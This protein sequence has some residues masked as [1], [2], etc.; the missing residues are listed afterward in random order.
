[1][2]RSIPVALLVGMW[3]TVGPPSARADDLGDARRA[4]SVGELRTAQ[5][6]LRNAV[7]SDPRNPAAHFLLGKVT[8]ELGDPVAAEREAIAARDR[9]FDPRQ[10]LTLLGQAL[11][12][13]GKYDRILQ[14]LTP[15]EKD[16][17]SD[18]AI[19]VT[20]G[21]AQF[22]LN[23]P[24]A[25][26]ASFARAVQL[27]PGAVEPLLA[28]ARLAMARS[29]FDIAQQK[30]DQ[31]TS[32]QPGSA[33]ALYL[34]AQLLRIRGDVDGAIAELDRLLKQQPAMMQARLSRAAFQLGKGRGDLAK[35][36]LDAVLKAM[37]GSVQGIYLRAVYDAQKQDYTGADH[38]LQRILPYMP[39]LPRAFYLQAVVKEQ[40]GQLEQAQDAIQKYLSTAPNELSGYKV[41]ARIRFAQHRPDQVVGTLGKVADNANA[42]AEIY[43]LL[44][45]A[46]AVTNQ[47]EAALTAFQ[48]GQAIAPADVGLQTRLAAVRMNL[49]QIDEAMT[50]LEQSLVRT[51][52]TPAI[53]EALFFAALATGDSDKVADALQKIKAAQGDTA[54]TRNLL[55]LSQLAQVDLPAARAT[56]S[57]LADENPDFTPARTN[58]ARVMLMM[59]EPGAAET[60]LSGVL[61]KSPASEPALAMLVKLLAREGREVAA[62]RLLEAAHSADPADLRAIATLGDLYIRSGQ[63]RRALDLVDQQ[64]GTLAAASELLTIRALAQLSL[65]QK[66][67]ASETYASILKDNPSAL[68]ARRQ[69]VALLVEQQDFQAARDIVRAGI[70]INPRNYQLYQDLTLIDVK[71]SGLDT[72]IGT[73]ARLAAQSRDFTAL[74][75]LKG[76]AYIAAD[77]PDRAIAAFREALATT[78]DSVLVARLTTTYLRTGRPGD[79]M[80]VL[81][82][83]LADH[84][85]DLSA[86]A[87]LSQIEITQNRLDDA[88]DLL[89]GILVQTPHDPVALN[90]LAWIYQQKNDP[91][92]TV[93][94]RRA[95]VLSPGPQTADTL[96]WILTA[97]GNAETGV[98]LL[99]QAEGE[100]V[101]DPRVRYHYAV[102][103][104]DLGQKAEAIRLLT[105]VVA[106]KGEFAEKADAQKL[107]TELG[108]PS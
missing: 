39:R 95:F 74:Q 52:E 72:A 90:N 56:F 62:E 87:Q 73:A 10:S 67:D 37:P 30:I 78:Q 82:A 104:K 14:A 13:Q 101:N 49:G 75:A 80:D 50:G 100:A 31:A 22:A 21:Y 58:L 4:L 20:R 63:P 24:D 81:Q 7:R 28:E 12:A 16:P 91:R 25:A 76:D 88:Q 2:R 65:G 5:I 98:S 54:L 61:A 26:Q 84:P 68:G 94:A 9:G 107:L 66:T 69:L 47:P 70:A 38:E 57:A 27:A 15:D 11:L 96:G 48:K 36:D 55:G 18:A 105:A 103:L 1:M 41:L 53:G 59:G 51:P 45:R 71:A 44:G 46:Y 43:G 40:L 97:S 35:P 108:R 93:L 34:A 42:D 79:A 99:R 32:V 17:Q 23:Q 3:I 19:L 86:K 106:T 33:D 83:W 60:L 89:E 64:K 8:I 6:M 102:A 77:Q 92:S 29:A 85:S